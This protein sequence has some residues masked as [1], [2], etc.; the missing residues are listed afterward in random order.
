MNSF[1]THSA[2]DLNIDNYLRTFA[3]INAIIGS[4]PKEV[5][6]EHFNSDQQEL[7]LLQTDVKS[8]LQKLCTSSGLMLQ[9]K[10]K[11]KFKKLSDVNTDFLRS[12]QQLASLI[13]RARKDNAMKDVKNYFIFKDERDFGDVEFRKEMVE[14]INNNKNIQLFYLILKT[15]VDIGIKTQ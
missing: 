15:Y 10:N 5:V 1:G 13:F 6:K 2:S 11:V 7:S 14:G 4:T 9:S 12:P 8:V 3:V